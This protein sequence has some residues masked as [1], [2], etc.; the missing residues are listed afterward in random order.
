L[1]FGL[2]SVGKRN[3]FHEMHSEINYSVHFS[4]SCGSL[5]KLPGLTG[6]DKINLLNGRFS[7]DAPDEDRQLS[8]VG[9][10][11]GL[12]VPISTT[13][14]TCDSSKKLYSLIVGNNFPY[15]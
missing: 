5:N 10:G 9:N 2:L 3:L 13:L 15:L 11:L 12:K 8:P 14:F 6:A 4:S 7:A 1:E